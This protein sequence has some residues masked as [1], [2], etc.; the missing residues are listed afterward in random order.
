M[1]SIPALATAFSLIAFVAVAQPML[2]RCDA[3]LDGQ[4]TAGGC[5]C[6][7]DRGGTLT[8][9]AAGWRWACDLLRGPG[10]IAPVPSAGDPPQPLPPGFIYAPQRGASTS[11]TSGMRY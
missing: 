11:T 5:K 10:V 9:R 4:V 6:G 1:T 8:G 7:Y 3:A 2:P